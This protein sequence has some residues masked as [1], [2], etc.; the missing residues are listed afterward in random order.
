[1]DKAFAAFDDYIA[2]STI[3]RCRLRNAKDFDE[4]RRRLL[5]VYKETKASLRSKR[6]L[7]SF[8]RFIAFEK[9]ALKLRRESI[10]KGELGKLDSDASI[11]QLRKAVDADLKKV[12]KQKKK[13][14]RLKP[15][16]DAEALYQNSLESQNV[17]IDFLEDFKQAIDELNPALLDQA[18]RQVIKAS[19][20]VAERDSKLLL[21]FR[22]F[23]GLSTATRSLADRADEMEDA[24][25]TVG[26][27]GSE[28]DE[29]ARSRPQPP[30]TS[31][32][33][34]NGGGGSG[35]GSGGRVT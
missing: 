34:G 33:G 10:A 28:R 22:Y 31:P 23:S 15:H 9:K 13:R 32:G 21:K 2:S 25:A 35:G 3:P 18:D 12:K 4:I 29:G 6:W 26:P 17:S 7:N 16:P 30:T 8:S 24:V 14:L 5:P 19:K 27:E 11:D 1:M 20:R